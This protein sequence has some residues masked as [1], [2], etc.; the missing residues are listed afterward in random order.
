MMIS[1]VN[2][3]SPRVPQEARQL[4]KP[5]MRTWVH[6]RSFAESKRWLLAATGPLL[7]AVSPRFRRQWVAALRGERVPAK[8]RT[9]TGLALFVVPK[10]QIHCQLGR[11]PC[12]LFLC[13]VYQGPTWTRMLYS[14]VH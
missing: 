10:R 12:P 9:T 14:F 4:G 11:C 6:A 7:A 2:P 8:A 1:T 13:L 5:C 3:Y